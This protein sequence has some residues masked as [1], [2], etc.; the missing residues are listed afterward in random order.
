MAANRPLSARDSLVAG[1]VDDVVQ[2]RKPEK[3]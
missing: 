2:T 1:L 3:K